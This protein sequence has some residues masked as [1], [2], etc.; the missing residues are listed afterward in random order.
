MSNNNIF[1][2][3][4]KYHTLGRCVIP[5][6]GGPDGKSALI[7]WKRYQ[8]ERPTD[9]QLQEWQNKLKPSVWAMPT[10]PVSG[11]FVVDTDTPGAVAMMEDSRLK[12]HVIT[13]R[14][15]EHF[16]CRWLGWAVATKAGILPGVD[17]RGVGGYVNFAGE[18]TD[19][20]YQV[21]IWPTDDSLYT[22]EQ[23][24]VKLQQALRAQTRPKQSTITPVA[25][26]IPEG[27]RND[28]LTRL[29]GSMRHKG[30]S[31]EAIYAT[32]S[33]VN[34]EQCQPL[35]PDDEV[36]QIA[37]SVG[38]YTPAQ[39][40]APLRE[41]SPGKRTSMVPLSVWRDRVLLDPPSDDLIADILPNCPSEYLL[42]CGRS[43]IGKT[44]LVLGMTFSLATGQPWFSHKTKQCR[45]GY[46][47]FEGSPKKLLTRFDKLAKS[48]PDTK[49]NLLVDRALPFK[50]SGPGI[51]QLR[52]T[53]AGLDVVII[54]PIRYIVPGDYTK[55]EAASAF[56]TTLKDV[57]NTTCTIPIL[58]HHVRKPDRRLT[59]RPEDLAF[60][61]KGA[62]D[63]VDAAGTVLLLERARQARSVDGRF[64]SNA[65]DRVLHFCKVKDSPTEM[66]PLNLRFNRDTLIYEPMTAEYYEENDN[67]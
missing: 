32:L 36:R 38:R 3:A 15:G 10:G 1:A 50:L 58:I 2:T 28:A 62:T 64:G 4:Y 11:V 51:N 17:I 33:I 47:G 7:Q 12:P 65:D 39:S 30:L 57:C 67:F 44:N 43:S 49:G 34:Q 20:K 41:K 5:S 46:L 35:L 37:E 8:I 60:E 6:G 66:Y 19:G 25:E 52:T 14:K 61:V 29:A 54:D 24:P 27:Q 13:P 53:L 23:L 16:Y 45:V 26:I 31:S 22:F 18:T 9:A 48:F 59:V 21:L 63:Y 56:I 42:L 40:I 55:P